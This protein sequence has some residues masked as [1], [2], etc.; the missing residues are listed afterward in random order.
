M[1]IQCDKP[2]HRGGTA[3]DEGRERALNTVGGSG[4]TVWGRCDL[5]FI[6]KES[7]SK[8]KVKQGDGKGHSKCV[9]QQKQSHGD[10]KK[11]CYIL[12]TEISLVKMWLGIH[13]RE[14]L[15][16]NHS[17]DSVEGLQE[18]AR[19]MRKDPEAEPGG[20]SRRKLSRP[21]EHQGA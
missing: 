12:E 16:A 13:L 15:Q 6:L 5:N 2:Q 11:A 21:R 3:R 14:L 17:G 20:G 7:R 1:T 9:K 18:G 4:R 8:E 10:S 19:P